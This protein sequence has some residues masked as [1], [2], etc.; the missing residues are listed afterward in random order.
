MLADKFQ[1][2]FKH[3]QDL[4]L[5]PR[6]VSRDVFA[7]K[8]MTLDI[9]VTSFRTRT[10][11]PKH[12]FKTLIYS[13]GTLRSADAEEWMEQMDRLVDQFYWEAKWGRP[14]RGGVRT[15]AYEAKTAP[16]K[17]VEVYK[18]D[19]EVYREVVDIFGEG[20]AESGVAANPYS[21][22]LTPEEMIL[23]DEEYEALQRIS[24]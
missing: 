22:P 15:R 20:D 2:L 16:K 9:H 12:L 8:F 23:T 7:F 1:P 6:V 10:M 3:A 11:N 13:S 24:V 14:T 18:P 17:A 19:V 21:G 5:N 4:G